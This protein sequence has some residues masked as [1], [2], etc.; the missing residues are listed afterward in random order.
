MN[1]VTA[2]DPV[3]ASKYNF[4]KALELKKIRLSRLV[5]FCRL[6]QN[7]VYTLSNNLPS[8]A[9]PTTKTPTTTTFVSHEFMSKPDQEILF[10]LKVPGWLAG[11]LLQRLCQVPW[12]PTW[13]L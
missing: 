9:I 13:N 12:M 1:T 7:G 2:T 10:S 6:P 3:N 5:V 8:G 4:K 11:T